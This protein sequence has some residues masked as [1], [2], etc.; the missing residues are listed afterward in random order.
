MV[1]SILFLTILVLVFSAYINSF[2]LNSNTKAVPSKIIGGVDVQKGEYPFMTALYQKS[3]LPFTDKNNN[4]MPYGYN[5]EKKTYQ[6][7]IKSSLICGGTLI[8]PQWIVTAAHCLFYFDNEKYAYKQ[9]TKEQIGIA[10]NVVSLQDDL[11]S[12]KNADAIFLDINSI[13]FPSEINNVTDPTTIPDNTDIA[14]IKLTK[15]VTNIIVPNLP[16]DKVTYLKDTS[17][18]ALGWGLTRNGAATVLQKGEFT[19]SGIDNGL[20]QTG[21]KLNILTHFWKTNIS[22]DLKTICRGDSGGPLLTI[23]NGQTYIIGVIVA[24]VELCGKIPD[25][26]LEVNQH[27]DWIL[28]QIGSTGLYKK[29]KP[30]T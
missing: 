28:E 17:V 29:N 24:G 11:K 13:I 12:A 8:S 23:S 6:Y 21:E 18:I 3:T 1:F 2:K 26:Y 27:K 9:F 19:I 15:D 20:I 16:D 22:K 4:K 10:L 14:L 7:D 5:K 25:N 30:K